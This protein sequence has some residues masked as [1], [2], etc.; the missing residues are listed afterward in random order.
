MKY[1]LTL[2]GAA[3]LGLSACSQES[4]QTPP[5][6]QSASPAASAASTVTSS[7]PAASSSPA[8][9]NAAASN[10][11]L[12][13]EAN[14]TMKYNTGEIAISKTC[15]NFNI[16]LKNTGTLPKTAMGHDLV[17]AKAAD[18]DA[19]VSDGASAGP[20]KHFLKTGD[21]RVIAHT[22]LIGPGE[23]ASISID[24]AK[25]SAGDYEFFCT[26]PGHLANMR[27]KIKLVD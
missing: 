12:T 3:I 13:V 5:A 25:L 17:I 1:Y 20:D 6:S 18:V 24:P 10:C 23:E 11:S 16:T 19:I 8:T 2:I 27:G 22:P 26:F 15:K 7:A 9:A 4:G 14:D 21:S